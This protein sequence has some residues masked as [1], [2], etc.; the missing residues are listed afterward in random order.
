MGQIA[1]MS[2]FMFVVFPIDI[3]DNENEA[4]MKE[5]DKNRDFINEQIDKTF[6]GIKTESKRIK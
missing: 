3:N 6:S 5:L 4:I 1:W 2:V